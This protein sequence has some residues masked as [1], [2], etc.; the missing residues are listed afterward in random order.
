MVFF[1]CDRDRLNR[2]LGACD[3]R[4]QIVLTVDTK[5]LLA[6]HAERVALTPFNSGNARRKP[7]IRGRA[8]FVPYATWLASAW[9]SEAEAMGVRE[10]PSS[11]APVEL[12]VADALRDVAELIVD[13]EHVHPGGSCHE[14]NV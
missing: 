9:R 1:W 4:P 5:P 6:R 14:R 11:H 2:Q 8:T 12:T 13:I 3:G 10:R 7:A